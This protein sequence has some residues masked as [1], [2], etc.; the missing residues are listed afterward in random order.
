MPSGKTPP[1]S[2][3]R[4][5]SLTDGWIIL[6]EEPDCILESADYGPAWDDGSA[7]R[8]IESWIDNFAA[9]QFPEM[10]RIIVDCLRRHQES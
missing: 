1:Y 4:V 3:P 8:K 10:N 2:N 7:R 9:E 5:N 6:H